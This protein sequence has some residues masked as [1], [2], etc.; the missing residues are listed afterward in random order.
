MPA[1]KHQTIAIEWES[2]WSRKMDREVLGAEAEVA[3][4]TGDCVCSRMRRR[5]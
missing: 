3:R 2:A 1:M 4:E 5:M